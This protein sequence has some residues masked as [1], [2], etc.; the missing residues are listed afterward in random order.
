M[1]HNFSVI[2]E[3]LQDASDYETPEENERAMLTGR[4]TPTQAL[5]ALSAIESR[6][7]ELK[8]MLSDIAE[9]MENEL[10]CGGLNPLRYPPEEIREAISR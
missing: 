2:R 5:V 10:G 7:A 9:G 4:A 3:V 6:V 1:K 8:A